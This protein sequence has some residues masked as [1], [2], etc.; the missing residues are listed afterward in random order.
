MGKDLKKLYIHMLIYKFKVVRVDWQ[1]D[2]CVIWLDKWLS[3]IY[4][5]NRLLE[6]TIVLSPRK[7]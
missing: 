4:E 1:K 5:P 7:K 2:S 6:T 3:P